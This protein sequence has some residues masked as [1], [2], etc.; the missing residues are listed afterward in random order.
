MEN[1]AKKD[2]RKWLENIKKINAPFGDTLCSRVTDRTRVTDAS[3]V[4][5]LMSDSNKRFSTKKFCFEGGGPEYRQQLNN[6]SSQPQ[7]C[8]NSPLT[9]GLDS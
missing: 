3:G 9:S 4:E 6:F 2:G 7:I 5:M 8:L 1:K